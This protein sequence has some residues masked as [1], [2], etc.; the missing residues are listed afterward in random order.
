[1]VKDDC[2]N[3]K[4]IGMTN[5]TCHTGL[6]QTYNS[7]YDKLNN[8]VRLLSITDT[9]KTTRKTISKEGKIML[10]SSL[11]EVEVY[12]ARLDREDDLSYDY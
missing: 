5:A 8:V 12:N 11:L 2:E 1:M 7:I 9:H 6:M 4:Q 3:E 10:L